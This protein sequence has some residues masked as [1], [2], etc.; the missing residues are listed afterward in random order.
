MREK[1]RGFLSEDFMWLEFSGDAGFYLQ[2]YCLLCG[3]L[4]IVE[5][6]VYGINGYL[7]ICGIKN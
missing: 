2:L 3:P 1:S 6:T 5:T 4:I 7:S